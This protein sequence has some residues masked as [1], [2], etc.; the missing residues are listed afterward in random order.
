MTA[1]DHYLANPMH[2]QPGL[3][4]EGWPLPDEPNVSWWRELT[5][6]EGSLLDRISQSLPQVRI[7]ISVGV[8]KTAGYADA[9][10]RGEPLESVD[11]DRDVPFR[12]PEEIALRVWSHFAGSLP[13]L[14]TPDRADFVRLYRALAGRCEPLPMPDG[15]HAVFISGVP[16]PGRTR[17]LREA[18]QSRTG[19]SSSDWSTEMARLLAEDRVWFYDRLVLMHQSPYG[20]VAVG[21]V[22][23]GQTERVWVDRSTVL[24]R[25]HEFT[26]YATSR[27]LGSFRL[28]LHD[29][30]LADF[31]GFTTALGTFSSEV[32]LAAMGVEGENIP[33]EAR[34]RYYTQGLSEDENRLVLDLVT[35]AANSLQ[36]LAAQLP[37]DVSRARLLL[38]LAEF[39]LAA[40]AAEGLSDRVLAVV[41]R[42]RCGA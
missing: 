34:F 18:W 36:V 11:L 2:P 24:R 7:A 40:L 29:E 27:M 33:E 30:L 15:V 25:E 19:G 20:G 16:N 17:A 35:E 13:V 21:R 6:G 28:N 9:V 12:R 32:F 3:S 39:D 8:S 26:H 1:L 5:A 4:G 38:A 10:L 37:A 41:D 14:E 22:L 23:P 31:M 42:W